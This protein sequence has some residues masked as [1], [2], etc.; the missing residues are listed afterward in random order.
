M[1]E[2]GPELLIIKYLQFLN[3]ILGIFF[4]CRTALCLLLPLFQPTRAH[5]SEKFR[6]REEITLRVQHNK[7]KTFCRDFSCRSHVFLANPTCLLAW[8]DSLVQR[9]QRKLRVCPS[10]VLYSGDGDA[11][12]RQDA[13]KM[14]FPFHW[15]FLD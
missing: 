15:S 2:P 6:K 12:S 14:A 13:W 4:H 11:D 8:G 9:A 10:T 7:G 3:D 5:K 1:T